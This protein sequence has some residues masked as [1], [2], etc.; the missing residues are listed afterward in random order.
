MIDSY[1]LPGSSEDS[2]GVV[3]RD[4]LF[5]MILG[6][7][8]V[9]FLINLLINPESQKE[10]EIPIKGEIVI[11]A[12]WPSGTSY[13]V[14]LWV[15]GPDGVPVGWGQ[16]ETTPVLNLERDDRGVINDASDINYEMISVRE[17]LPGEYIVNLHLYSP[18]SEPLPVPVTVSVVGKDDLGEIYSGVSVITERPREITVVRFSLGEDGLVVN[19][20]LNQDSIA[21]VPARPVGGIGS[22]FTP[23]SSGPLPR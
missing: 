12:F 20:S 19:D 22:V 16:H 11:Q 7:V 6:M 18:Y 21:I 14:D 15:M 9:I 1:D 10:H 5:L 13:D 2:S 23:N 8:A 3:F 4:T 17:R